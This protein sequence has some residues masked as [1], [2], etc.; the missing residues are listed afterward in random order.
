MFLAQASKSW[1]LSDEG[2]KLKTLDFTICIQYKPTSGYYF[3]I[4]QAIHCPLVID[5]LQLAKVT[6]V[7]DF[8]GAKMM[9]FACVVNNKTFKSQ[10]GRT[11]NI[12][13]ECRVVNII[14]KMS[15]HSELFK[16]L[17]LTERERNR[18]KCREKGNCHY[19]RAPY[20]AAF[21]GT[22]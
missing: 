21:N 15:N 8:A 20:I 14:S 4:G 1:F 6:D 13:I 22:C 9:P 19:N 7:R 10:N 12:P 5:H 11:Y 18:E 16:F 3:L 17:I 2:P